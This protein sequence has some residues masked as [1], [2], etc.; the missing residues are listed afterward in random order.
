MEKLI[1]FIVSIILLILDNSVVPFLAIKGAYPSLLFTFAIAYSLIRGKEKSV[2]IGAVSGILQDIFFG[3]IFGVNSLLNL[4]LCLFASIIGEG[5]FRNKRLIPVASAF[6]ITMLKYIGVFII[7]YF[8]RIDIDFSGSIEM[9][10]YNSVIM[11]FGYRLVM[12]FLDEEYAKRT[13]RFKW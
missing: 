9:S 12:R 3:G 8:A 10:L 1:V 6:A 2:F 5:I 7:F 11:F 13:W 4:L